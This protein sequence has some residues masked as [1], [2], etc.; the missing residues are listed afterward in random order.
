MKTKF[1]NFR[2]IPERPEEK[3]IMEYINEKYWHLSLKRLF[4]ELL[5]KD[6]EEKKR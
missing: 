6:M 2:L 3:K 1:V 5:K 4:I